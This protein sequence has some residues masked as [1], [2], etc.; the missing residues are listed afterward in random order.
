VDPRDRS[1]LFVAAV[2]AV[3]A[4]VLALTA[5]LLY[6]VAV[7]LGAVIVAV[8]LAVA[9]TR[10]GARRDPADPGR[11]AF[12]RNVGLAGVGLV[13]AGTTAGRVA[14][15]LSRPDPRPAIDAMARGLGSEILT[16]IRRGH[17]PR[18]TG[19]LQLAL[20]PFT[21]ANY[22]N[23]SLALAPRDPRTS[24]AAPWMYLQRV[25]IVA[26]GPGVVGE[27]RDVDERV[28][29]ADLAPTTAQLMGFDGFPAPDGRPLPG[30]ARPARPPKVVVTFVIDGGGW[31]ALTLW[32]Q[33]W[34]ELRAMMRDG[35]VYR[36]AVIGSFPA[37]TASAHATIGTGAFPWKHGIVGH[38]MR[39]GGNVLQPF[40]EDGDASTERILVPTLAE[41]WAEETGGRAWSGVLAYQIWH[42]SMIGAPSPVR[43]GRP[44]ATYFDEGDTR[45]RPQH[46]ETYRLPAGMPDRSVLTGYVRER[47]PDDPVRAEEVDASGRLLCCEAP[48]VRYQGDTI[49]SAFEHEPIGRGD[50]TD[51]LYI[52]YK[53]PDY[54]GH[55]WNVIHPR[56]AE[57]I[58]AVDREL[59][60]L[61][62]LLEARFGDGNFV[63]IVTADHGQS[64]LPDATGG[65]RVD[66]I[67][68]ETVLQRAFGPT[69]L[70]FVKQVKPS[71]IYLHS[72]RL[73]EVGAS[74]DDL[75]AFLRDLRYGETIGTYM[76][77]DAVD[78]RRLDDRLF[79]A[80]L[81]NTFVG[82]L[83]PA[84]IA[85][86]GEG[87]FG[88]SDPG[89]PEPSW[90]TG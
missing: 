12:V 26:Y 3:A 65:A 41:A 28:S 47:Y 75:A 90:R 8:F 40:G 48:V 55:T 74:L 11:R 16:Y 6:A 83:S 4:A 84:A 62:R 1:P 23:E 79:A 19:E 42:L 35:V 53:A 7:G 18:R 2:G 85:R 89:I 78:D 5:G 81:P 57:S 71:E 31:N 43:G 51:L 56:S 73:W 87:R 34:P 27:P 58:E 30:L 46:P 61:R 22:R 44:V 20:A 52:N 14:A 37:V 68:L 33:A 45:F 59:G 77:S 15:R 9:R 17:F 29:L 76:A 64:P 69:I 39:E 86:Y 60:R 24:H 66:P 38:N 70:P 10:A 67:Q 72:G 32:P 25:P 50:V 36:D 54:A 63:L 21:V 13:T 49:V 88:A 80:V 82:S